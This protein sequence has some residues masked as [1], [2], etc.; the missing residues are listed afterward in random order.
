MAFM[1]LLKNLGSGQSKRLISTEGFPGGPMVKNLPANAGGMGSIPGLGVENPP[2]SAGTT[3]SVLGA[4]L[5]SKHLSPCTTT[6]EP[7]SHNY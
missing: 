3:G 7:M 6:T 5:T 1:N 4:D 2:A